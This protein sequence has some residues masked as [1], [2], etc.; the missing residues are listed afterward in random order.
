ME[1]KKLFKK[2]KNDEVTTKPE[3]AKVTSEEESEAER[4]KAKTLPALLNWKSPA[5]P[6][7]KKSKQYF[8]TA[9]IIS[10]VFILVSVLLQW[11]MAVGVVLTLLFLAYV[12]GTVEPEIIDHKIT[13]KGLVSHNKV[14]LWRDLKGFWF[15][16]SESQ[17]LL[18]LEAKKGFPPRMVILLGSTTTQAISNILGRYLSEKKA[19]PTDFLDKLAKKMSAWIPLE[20]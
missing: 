20:T 19:P 18:V 3:E 2:Q 16:K 6:F 11:W 14:F 17:N 8:S 15:D 10:L 13:G 5:R 1:T 4:E 12:L 7:Q 9:G